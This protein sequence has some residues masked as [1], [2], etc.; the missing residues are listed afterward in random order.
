MKVLRLV[1]RILGVV[2]QALS[3]VP[4]SANVRLTRKVRD[5]NTS[6]GEETET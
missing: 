6:K 4:S 5:E 3:S 1:L 2:I